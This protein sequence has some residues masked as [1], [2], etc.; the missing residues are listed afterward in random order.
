MPKPLS[1]YGY[2]GTLETNV[3]G[4]LDYGFQVKENHWDWLGHGIYFWQDAPHR[5][6]EWGRFWGKKGARIAVLKARIVL[7]DCVDLLDIA[8][9]ATIREQADAF[10]DKIAR[11]KDVSLRNYRRGKQ[12]GRHELDCAF[13]EYLHGILSEVG[14]P[15]R[16]VR[17][18]VTEGDPILEDS[19]ICY[20]S[21]VQIAVRDSTLIQ[22]VEVIYTGDG[23]L[24]YAQ[25]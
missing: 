23:G 1:I 24:D 17:A 2:H 25:S 5:A 10:T 22:E 6:R 7:T 13:F 20:R 16:C 4:I 9:D 11:Q 15:F 12:K 14:S 19:P 8:W 3:P 21:H 18:A